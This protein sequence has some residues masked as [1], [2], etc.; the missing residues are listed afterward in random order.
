MSVGV[1]KVKEL[2]RRG[3]YSHGW[4]ACL[5]QEVS[6]P[7][8]QLYSPIITFTI[9]RQLRAHAQ[10]VS[11]DHVTSAVCVP[12]TPPTMTPSTQLCHSAPPA[13]RKPAPVLA[14]VVVLQKFCDKNVK[15]LF[16]IT[17]YTILLVN[18]YSKIPP[19]S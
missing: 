15:M 1:A 17:M 13:I 4:V 18:L 2:A 16:Y 8:L 3:A 6:V 9:Q 5:Q 12:S 10:E 19:F 7:V 14:D 11:G